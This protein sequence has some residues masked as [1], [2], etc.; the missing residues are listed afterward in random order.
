MRQIVARVFA[1][2]GNPGNF[3][4]SLKMCNEEEILSRAGIRATAIRLLIFK[5]IV[6]IDRTFNLSE[7]EERL[8]TVDKST[9]F[10]TLT[11]FQQHHILHEVDNGSGSKLYCLCTCGSSNH[12]SHIHFTCTSC[13]R[14]FCIKDITTS[15]IPLPK[16]FEVEEINCVMKGLCPECRRRLLNSGCSLNPAAQ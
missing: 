10:R 4:L 13:H 2:F 16:D 1:G 6:R 12:T 15:S 5:E 11:L 8:D 3:N 7:M 9:L 14:T